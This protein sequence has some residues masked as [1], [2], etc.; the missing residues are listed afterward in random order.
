MVQQVY[1]PHHQE[2]LS[3]NIGDA[4]TIHGRETKRAML[5]WALTEKNNVVCFGETLP[6][7]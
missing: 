5:A 2:I 6:K 7:Q 1:S 4:I 3:L